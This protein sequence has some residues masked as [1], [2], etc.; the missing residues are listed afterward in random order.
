MA[1]AGCHLVW[2]YIVA[3]SEE[4][5]SAYPGRLSEASTDVADFTFG[6]WLCENDFG[7]PKSP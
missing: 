6:S 4:L 1:P 5:R 7:S 2:V 3:K